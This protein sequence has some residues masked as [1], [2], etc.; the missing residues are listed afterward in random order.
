MAPISR[1]D[2]LI[3]G[4]ATSV[5]A[6]VAGVAT[7]RLAG[8]S[9]AKA[10]KQA[11]LAHATAVRDASVSFLG[12]HQ[13][14]IELEL[15]TFTN[16]L[17]FQV[18]SKLSVD[19]FER[20]MRLLTEDAT[21][22][23]RGV[24]VLADAQPQL[25]LGPARLTVT[26]GLGPRLFGVLGIEH[27]RPA[28]FAEIPNQPVDKLREEF[29]GGDLLLHVSADD[30]IVLSHAVRALIR[31]S[32][33]FATVKWS[34]Q[35]FS[36]AQGVTPGGVRQRNLMGQVDGTDNP[37]LGSQHFEEVV[38][39]DADST[40][41]SWLVGGTQLVLRRIAMNLDTWDKL[42]RDEKERVIGR[43][44][45]NGAPLG[46]ANE[47]DFPDFNARKANGLP[48]IP[49][50]AHIRNAS[51]RSVNEIF[52]RRP[53]NY[54]AGVSATGHPD[55]GLLWTAYARD[56]AKQYLPVQERLSKVDMLNLWTTPI[57]SSVWVIPPGVTEQG[58]LLASTL[59]AA[60]RS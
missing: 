30:P 48:Q 31:D 39:I 20:W 3:T 8:E 47:T 52:F 43:N 44:L 19:D 18:D 36:N 35:G 27:L 50:Y 11:E 40:D 53:F 25:A 55:V 49:N 4:V 5:G 16:F 56:L 59:I 9:S 46:Q 45:S 54:E 7:S 29:S 51:A 12:K 37:Q 13:A 2:V 22:L 23:A 32:L 57:G 6:T 26:L 24:P 34:Q 21:R 15:Q 58:Q 41:Q 42:G 17:S 10:L 38:W 14:G 33:P 28:G 1:R 60:A